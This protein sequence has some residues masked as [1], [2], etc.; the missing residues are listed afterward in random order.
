MAKNP[1]LILEPKIDNYDEVMNLI[2]KINHHS[3]A[4]KR[5]IQKLEKK[6]ILVSI[7]SITQ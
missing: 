5:T 6:G 1:T 7:N 2:T 3:K 4:L